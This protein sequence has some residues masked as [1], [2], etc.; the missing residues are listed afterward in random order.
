AEEAVTQLGLGVTE[1]LITR[2]S[3]HS[4]IGVRPVT[5]HLQRHSADDVAALGR[6]LGVKGVLDGTIQRLG[7]RV[8]VTMRLVRVRDGSVMSA[9]QFDERLG[10]P[11]A[12]ADTMSERITRALMLRLNA[13]DQQRLRGQDTASMKAYHA[14]LKGRF[15]WERRTEESLNRGIVCFEQAIEEDPGYA[16]AYLGLADCYHL[17]AY[18]GALSPATC[19][20]RVTAAALKALEYDASLGVAHTTLGCVHL[21]YGWDAVQAARE[22]HQA[23]ELDPEHPRVHQWSSQCSLAAGDVEAALRAMERA[24]ERDPMSVMVNTNI[25]IGLYYAR[26]HDDSIA[27][28]RRAIEIDPHFGIAHWALGVNY[29]QKGAYDEAVRELQ[30]GLTLS[31]PSVP[32]LSALGHVYGVS[33][34]RA[35]AR[36]ILDEL[37]RL[38][39]RRYVSPYCVG[40]VH[41][42]LGDT[43][44]AFHW[45]QQAFDD[46]S[47]W[48][49]YL[50]V[51]PTLDRLRSDR[52]FPELL[53]R[54]GLARDERLRTPARSLRRA[55]G[56][57]PA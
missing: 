6:G 32:M 38:S 9:C 46:R 13:D 10:D 24:R 14:Y 19:Y 22:F 12:V 7:D 48:L 40:V 37:R 50:G 41:A 57:T 4:E 51:D 42:G 23:L 17:L 26:R 27:E 47:T 21:F 2:L 5:R 1:A 18:F 25:A 45:L 33:G 11:L 52:R 31:A 3:R 15:F 44:Q 16:S 20:P 43:D 54:I 30:K 36:K 55:A 35:K 28:L 49:V 29:E 53:R 56:V 39:S 8:R 34:R